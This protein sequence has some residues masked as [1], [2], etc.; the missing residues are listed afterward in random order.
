[1]ATPTETS[2]EQLA[3]LIARCIDAGDIGRGLA[4]CQQ[5]NLGHPDYAY[6]WYLASFLLKKAGKPADG[7]KAIDRA[8]QLSPSGKY[9]LQRAK[10]LLET[11]DLAA[12]KVAGTE[13][14]GLSSDDADLHN[15]IGTLLYQLG[16]FCGALRH[17]SRA[18]AI[19]DGRAEFHFNK[20]ALQR[21]LGDA[22]GA[23]ASFD[24]VITLKPDE[25]EAYAGRAQ[26]R[27][28]TLAQNHIPELQGLISRTADPFGVTQLCYALA[29]EQEDIG[30]FDGAFASLEQGAST[31]R[32][33]MQ[34]QVDTDLQIMARIR[35]VYGAG[36]F[37][38]RIQG[39]DAPDPIFIIG[40][41]RTGTTLVERILGSHSAV[42]SAGELNHF[43]LELI[44]LTKSLPGAPP[45][46]RLE[47]VSRT[48]SLDFR[49]LGE[50][51]LGATR[52]LRD[53][54]PF[55]IDKL[56]FNF[57]YA[58]LIHLALPKAKIIN[59]RRHP[60][61][62][63]FAVYKQWFKDAYP[64]SYDLDEL[65]QYYVAYLQLMR[66][67]N[68]VMPGVIHTVRYEDVVADVEGESR[69]LLAYCGLP[70]EDQCL[71]FHENAQPS[72]TAS[73]VQVRQPIYDRSVGK[74]KKFAAHLE[75]L[76]LYLEQS[77][78]DTR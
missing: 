34:Y 17:Y 26:L 5:L 61:D 48:A 69:R 30:D 39:H 62:T 74:W 41:P 77:G 42:F 10:C 33:H 44:R 9:R 25:Y 15:E 16:D 64:F 72:T 40:M 29:K 60:M 22:E 19:D 31:K 58:G 3:E 1:M 32:R 49:A 56:P 18:I 67:W 63:C 51:Y 27:T 7:L 13:L 47:F 57:L 37:D 78:V 20:A 38:G 28:Q 52:A 36:L 70:W 2:R 35:E 46:S 76:R 71:R 4:Y 68:E 75:P 23:E 73:A 24:S 53:G 14:E 8:L 43:S 6:G 55:F 21:Y 50:A 66:H 59:L 65:G 45:A 11:G 12:A 54:S